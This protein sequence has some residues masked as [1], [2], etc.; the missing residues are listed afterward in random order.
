LYWVS[1]PLRRLG[2]AALKRTEELV[3]QW[4]LREVQ[5]DT[6]DQRSATDHDEERSPR[7]PGRM[8]GVRDQDLQDRR[9][10]LNRYESCGGLREPAVRAGSSQA[11]NPAPG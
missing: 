3:G 1:S 9:V 11:D 2:Y 8:P 7:H 6:G 4:L 5:S 10:D